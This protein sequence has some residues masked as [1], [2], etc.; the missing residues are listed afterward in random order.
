M[1]VDT[2]VGDASERRRWVSCWTHRGVPKSASGT[3]I[4]GKGEVVG[5]PSNPKEDEKDVVAG[6]VE[7]DATETAVLP[8]PPWCIRSAIGG[9]DREVGGKGGECTTPTGSSFSHDRSTTRWTRRTRGIGAVPGGR[10]AVLLPS[11]SSLPT[12]PDDAAPSSECL[13]GVGACG[14]GGEAVAHGRRRVRRGR[15]AWPRPS[16]SVRVGSEREDESGGE[17]CVEGGSEP[18][19]EEDGGDVGKGGDAV[20]EG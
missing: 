1:A 16:A 18:S 17:A 15:P 4:E 10:P 5:R 19:T 2:Y 6:V 3:G 12:D 9:R 11:S 7:G 14:G 13:V 20:E 8:T